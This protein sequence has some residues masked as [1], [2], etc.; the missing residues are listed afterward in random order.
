M[1]LASPAREYHHWKCGNMGTDGKFSH[2]SLRTNQKIT[3]NLPSVPKFPA[4]GWQRLYS[5]VADR[6]RPCLMQA[7]GH[8]SPV[9]SYLLTTH[10]SRLTGA[11]LAAPLFLGRLFVCALVSSRWATLLRF[12][13]I[14]SLPTIHDSLASHGFGDRLERTQTQDPPSKT[15]DGAPSA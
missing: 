12:C 5:R 4:G 3:G 15:E 11:R 13:P 10:C 6:L 7:V 8:S 2:V 9:L 14:Y 1:V